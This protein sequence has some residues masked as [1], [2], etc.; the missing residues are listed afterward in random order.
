MEE[1]KHKGH[2]G[3][4]AFTPKQ[5]FVFGLVG[6]LLTLCTLGF[7]IMLGVVFMGSDSGLAYNG[8]SNTNNGGANQPAGAG[9]Q[10]Q[11]Q[12][13]PAADPAPVDEDVDHIRGAEDAVV[14]IIEYSD[15]Q[16]P[17]CGRFHPTMQKLLQNYGDKVR[18]VYRH[19]PL[20]SIHPN[21]RSLAHASEC[22]GE[23]NKFWE[24]A[25]AVIVDNGAAG[26]NSYATKVGLNI[27][28]FES[29]MNTG[30]YNDLITKQTNEAVAAGGTGTPYTVLIGKDGTKIPLSGAQPYE[31]VEAALKSLL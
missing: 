21:A 17:F 29:C 2:E 31:S 25:D 4:S 20:E 27:G 13:K 11:G 28:K 9:Q 15:F 22:A 23:Q 7:F 24:F 3:L 6:G 19:F 1:H 5:T 14:T 12:Q 18:W 16:C 8:G 30:K 26:V 10:P